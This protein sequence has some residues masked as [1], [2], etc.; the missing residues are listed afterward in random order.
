MYNI[1]P[2][3][4]IL[5]SLGIIIFIAVKKFPVLANV[6]VENIPKEKEAKFK[7]KIIIGRLKRNI[8]KWSSKI[9]RLIGP[10]GATISGFSH[11]A[12][13]KLHEIKEG[14]KNET[15]LGKVDI[16]K[17]ITSSLDEAENLIKEDDFETAEKKLIEAISLDSKNIEAFKALGE[18]Y[19]RKK[20]YSEASETLKHVLKLTEGRDSEAYFDLFFVC[21][22]MGDYGDALTNIN[23]ALEIEPNN[24]RYLDSLLEISIINKDKISA[25]KAYKKLKEANPE[26]QKLEELKK[27]VD[28]LS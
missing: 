24:P 3:I 14:Y 18:L 26:N 11:W 5:I 2:L 28:E 25:F 19:L 20:S 13:K 4:L 22:E 9:T 15:I 1:I 6:D 27:Q 17:K 10:L 21:K 7:E 23:S 12:L 16:D 8:I